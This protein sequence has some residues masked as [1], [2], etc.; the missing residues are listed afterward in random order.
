MNDIT[1]SLQQVLRVFTF[2]TELLFCSVIKSR[3]GQVQ[4]FPSTR[5]RTS[6]ILSASDQEKKN[7]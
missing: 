3:G 7:E 2:Y 6:S 1:I 4:T 5:T